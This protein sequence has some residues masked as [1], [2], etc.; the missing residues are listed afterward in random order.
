MSVNQIA[1]ADNLDDVFRLLVESGATDLHWSD[2][3]TLYLRVNGF[4]EIGEVPER[5][6]NKPFE[7]L[8]VH[9]IGRDNF[10]AFRKQLEYDG[11]RTVLGDYR[12]RINVFF[13]RGKIAW[14]VRLL[15]SEF[16]SLESLGLNLDICSRISELKQGLVLV[17]GATGSGKTTTLASLLHHINQQRREHIFTIE[18]PIEYV[19]ES[20]ECMVSQREVGVDTA[21]FHDALRAVLREDPDIV[22][23]GEM[24]DRISMDAAL[25]LSETGH[26]TFATLHTSGAVD[27][28]SRII[29]AFDSMEQ[30]QI[31]ERLATNLKFV[32]T[33][34]LIPWTNREG[35]SL[36]AEIM[37]STKAIRAMI[38][39]GKE[40]Q[41]LSAI[42]TGSDE[43][44]TTMN[45]S[46]VDLVKRRLITQKEA[47]LYTPDRD[48]LKRFFDV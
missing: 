29:S 16:F 4:L 45:K 8:T 24:R 23:L 3:G 10:E 37:V 32:I 41:M 17:T 36:C 21:S 26:L 7:E 22:L 5:L 15:P 12:I 28:I 2:G 27:T 39:D 33:Q 40:R 25:T 14:A 48:A 11:A 43:G 44:M 9:L 38:R 13:K 47:G 20:R 34:Q 35:R 19:H 6:A 30:G 42:E 31:R 46:L 1:N 18:D